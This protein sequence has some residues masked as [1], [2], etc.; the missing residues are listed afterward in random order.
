MP[1]HSR[2][3]QGWESAGRS[4]AAQSSALTRLLSWMQCTALVRSPVSR[5]MHSA[6][7]HGAQGLRRQAGQSWSAQARTRPGRRRPACR[8][9]LVG[10]S[11]ETLRS[12]RIMLQARRR[13][14][15]PPPQE[16]E[17]RLQGP[18]DHWRACS[19]A[20]TPLFRPFFGL[21]LFFLLFRFL[22]SAFPGSFPSQG[23]KVSTWQ[24]KE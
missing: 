22:P 16:R 3:R 6:L 15:S 17:Q 18:G 19:E 11:W 10:T 2:L 12:V 1:E 23:T 14:C 24:E 21:R 9:K 5:A 13:R 8:Q 20:D 7:V 4:E